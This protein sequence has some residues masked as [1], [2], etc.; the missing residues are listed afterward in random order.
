MKINSQF[1]LT[2]F[3]TCLLTLSV[4]SPSIAQEAPS[5]TDSIA[6]SY[7][8]DNGTT[9]EVTQNDDGSYEYSLTRDSDGKELES[10]HIN[11][12]GLHEFSVQTNQSGRRV[13]V[14]CVKQFRRTEDGINV[15]W[16]WDNG[17]SR[18]PKAP[19]YGDGAWQ[20]TESFGGTS[21]EDGRDYEEM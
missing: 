6:G 17:G 19:G 3:A 20:P 7:E 11:S 1:L 18:D 5:S 12:D 10:G 13:D 9:L 21:G 15:R 2:I 16:W 8:N 14:P 4:P